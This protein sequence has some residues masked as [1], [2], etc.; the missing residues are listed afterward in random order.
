MDVWLERSRRC[1]GIAQLERDTETRV[2]PSG[3]DGRESRRNTTAT[4]A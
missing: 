2:G 4:R 3:K 1:K